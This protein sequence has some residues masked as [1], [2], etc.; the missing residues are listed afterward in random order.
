LE[1]VL[2]EIL[3]DEI[4]D[5][6]DVS[7]PMR[8]SKDFRNVVWKGASSQ[9]NPQQ[10]KAIYTYLSTTL[11]EF[12]AAI[13]SEETFKSLASK[14]EVRH[15]DKPTEKD[16]PLYER[17]VP[18]PYFTLVLQGKVE[19]QSGLEG[20]R[21]EGGPFTFMGVSALLTD[22]FVP[23][24]SA[25]VLV[26][27][28]LLR[29]KKKQYEDA[30]RL[31]QA[32]QQKKGSGFV[33]HPLARPEPKTF[34]ESTTYPEKSR[35]K[36]ETTRAKSPLNIALRDFK[37]K[38]N[39]VPTDEQKGLMETDEEEEEDDGELVQLAASATAVV[40]AAVEG[41]NGIH[42]RAPPV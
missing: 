5:E 15:I 23:D 1:D 2:E 19:I 3:Q 9:L 21:S 40:N 28:Q 22:N 16:D 6:D 38:K 32:G 12:S 18:S 13:F 27:A 26:N 31:N 34:M 17:N 7:D 24:F 29:I 20:F 25:K 4:M 41:H 37:P 39:G 30:I 36:G 14:S 35:N 8:S 42:T 11:P 33:P 10:L